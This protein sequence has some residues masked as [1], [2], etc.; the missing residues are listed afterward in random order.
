MLYRPCRCHV[1]LITMNAIDS[2]CCLTRRSCPFPQLPD[3]PAPGQITLPASDGYRLGC[4]L[5]RHHSPLLCC[6]C[7]GLPSCPQQIELESLLQVIALLHL[8][9]NTHCITH[10]K[11]TTADAASLTPSVCIVCGYDNT[12]SVQEINFSSGI[13]H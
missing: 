6:R 10:I 5:R 11:A 2:A 1:S 12:W 7:G 9:T 3:G 8:C 13:L 4:C